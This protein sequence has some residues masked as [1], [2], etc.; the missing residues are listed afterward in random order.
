MYFTKIQL[1]GLS[2]VDLPIVGALPTDPY[3]LASADG[4]GPP[5]VDVSIQN[6]LNAGGVYQGRRPQNREIVLRVGL[7]PDFGIGQTAADLRTTLYGMLTPGYVDN[8][9]I[10]VMDGATI[11]ALTTG[12]VKKLEVVPFNIEPEVQITIACV[13]QYLQAP[14]PLYVEPP[15]KSAPEIVNVG[16]APAGFFMELTFTSNITN[17]ALVHATGAKME[18]TYA[19]LIGDI[20]TID[21]RPGSRKILLKRGLVTSNIIYALTPD[22]I[23]FLLHGGS[24]SFTT[25]SNAFNWGDVFYLPQYWGV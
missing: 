9:I 15:V 17:W 18:L 5:E 24:N 22:S 1:V 19:F 16:T 12:Y 7:N 4:L 20:L 2:T 6:T 13:Q 21:T 25:T 23:W 8:I 10:N 11:L 14:Y 3:I